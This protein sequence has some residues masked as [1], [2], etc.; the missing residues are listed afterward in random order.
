MNNK[1]ELICPV[2]RLNK[3]NVNLNMDLQDDRMN[4]KVDIDTK[5]ILKVLTDFIN[6]KF[7]K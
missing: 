1:T 5:N 4:I 3:T 6:N 7:K 2:K